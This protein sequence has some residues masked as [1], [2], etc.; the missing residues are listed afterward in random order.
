MM[1]L[2][3]RQEEIILIIKQHSPITSDEIGLKMGI[4]RAALRPDLAVLTRAGII[5]GKPRVGYRF[6]EDHPLNSIA[7]FLGR[8]LVKD[9]MGAAPL[10]EVGVSVY[11]AA[12]QMFELDVGSL[13]VVNEAGILEGIVS[14]KDL[15]K[16][17]VGFG[18]VRSL[19]VTVAMTRM[20]NVVTVGPEDPIWGAI[21]ELN[22]HKI[23]SLPVGFMEEKEGVHQFKVIGRFTK[24]SI[25][26]ILIECGL[27]DIEKNSYN[28]ST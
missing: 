24:T 19:P 5:N 28:E 2:T 20:P 6:Q 21:K 10:V 3:K 27:I 12:V 9:Y 14:R 18:D 8:I 7:D 26:R 15:L 25:V 1:K 13:F 22:D 16:I 17:A 4:S 11:D 23:D